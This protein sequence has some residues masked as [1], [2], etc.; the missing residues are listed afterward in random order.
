MAFTF[1]SRK[2][3]R[4]NWL[5][6]SWTLRGFILLEK[7]KGH[8]VNLIQVVILWLKR[9][10][11]IEKWENGKH[12]GA[13]NVLFCQRKRKDKSSPSWQVGLGAGMVQG[14]NILSYYFCRYKAELAY[15]ELW[16]RNLYD[17]ISRS[18]IFLVSF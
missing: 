13:L 2:N 7:K 10:K 18:C 11:I 5:Y 3:T 17:W 9:K 8:T 1:Y 6:V 15:V 4:C 14:V 16:Y 12:W